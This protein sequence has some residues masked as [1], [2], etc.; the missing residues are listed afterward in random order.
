MSNLS[1]RRGSNLSAFR[2]AAVILLVT[3]VLFILYIIDIAA[4]RIFLKTTNESLIYLWLGAVAVTSLVISI[5]I[6]KNVRKSKFSHSVDLLQRYIEVFE[7][8]KGSKKGEAMISLL[9]F[10][11]CPGLFDERFKGIRDFSKFTRLLNKCKAK[12]RVTMLRE[13]DRADFLGK[14]YET[15]SAN[16]GNDKLNEKMGMEG[17]VNDAQTFLK[18]CFEQR[19]NTD[20]NYIARCWY[21]NADENGGQFIVLGAATS[22]G[23]IGSA[24]FDD[25]EFKFTCADYHGEAKVVHALYDQLTKTYCRTLSEIEKP[26]GAPEAESPELKAT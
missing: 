13:S 26:S 1:K 3:T 18:T 9:H 20:K 2:Y 21:D 15:E 7:D 12:V 24:S 17:Y 8:A 25:G 4:D 6:L 10:A 16:V 19:D 11:P 14:F 5:Y 23:F 22:T